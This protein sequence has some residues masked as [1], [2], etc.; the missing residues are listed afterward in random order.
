[1]AEQARD[2]LAWEDIE[3]DADTRSRLDAS[4]LDR[5]NRFTTLNR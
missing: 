5:L 2:V 3:D 4:Q 1:M